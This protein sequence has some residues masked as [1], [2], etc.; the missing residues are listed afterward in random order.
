MKRAALAVA[1]VLVGGALG[2][3]RAPLRPTGGAPGGR[4][5]AP[6][7]G[8]GGAVGA[9]GSSGSG[10]VRDAGTID[11]YA[12]DVG[13][14]IDVRLPDAVFVG[15]DAAANTDASRPRALSLVLKDA[16]WSAS[17]STQGIAVDSAG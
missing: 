12:R 3:D 11:L 16:P 4:A 7:A 9:G 17:Q 15:P 1:V 10:G 14:P 2:C 13:V 8:A 5:G 6:A